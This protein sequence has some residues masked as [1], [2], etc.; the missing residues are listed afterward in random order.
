MMPS[1]LERLFAGMA[2]SLRDTVLPEIGDDYAR[3]QVAA[4][5]ELLGNLA[6]RVEWRRDHLAAVTDRAEAA[7]AA[8]T[9]AAPE[10]T[11]VMLTLTADA[12]EDH[13]G[14]VAGRDRALARVSAGLRWCDAHIGEQR[15]ETGAL[16]PL[17][18]FSKWHLEHE[19]ALLRT[20]MFRR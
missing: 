7:V 16:P 4:C 13:D 3:A 11:E 8:A 15:A 6:T 14:P 1:S 2:D 12:A 9:A 19:L 17:I 5:I 20:G 18:D 10:L